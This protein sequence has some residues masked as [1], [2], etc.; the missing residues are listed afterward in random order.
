MGDAAGVNGE[1]LQIGD[2]EIDFSRLGKLIT[3][4]SS[5]ISFHIL[6]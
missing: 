4:K 1:G 5:K 6:L 2:G 3:N